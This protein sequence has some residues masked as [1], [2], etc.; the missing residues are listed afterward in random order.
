M[1]PRIALLALL[2]LSAPTQANRAPE[3][4]VDLPPQG[5]AVID[6]VGPVPA[7]AR[8]AGDSPWVAFMAP[9]GQTVRVRFARGLE[10]DPVVAQGYVDFLGSLVHGT[11]LARLRMVISPLRAVARRCGGIEGTLACYDPS[12]SQMTV[13][14][15]AVAEEGDGV[16][17]SYVIAHEYGHH[18]ARWRDNR[19]FNALA[20]GPKLWAS[21][22]LVCL[23]ALEDRLAPGD[24]G[25]RYL[26]N[27][28]EAWAS[29]YA[30]LRYP[31]THWQY[32][33]LLRPD[34]AAYAAALRDV[35]TP[36]TRS[37]RRELTGAFGPAGPDRRA[38]PVTL[39]LDGSL[40]IALDGP[41][42]A[43]YDVVIRSLGRRQGATRAAGADDVFRMRY[44][45]REVSAERLSVA[46]VRRSGRGPFSLTVT[47]AG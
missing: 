31:D 21:H 18:V 15:E 4:L 13:P 34:R 27:P 1:V 37:Q 22:E 44:A 23:H 14:G 47:Y 26:A 35:G 29:T 25:E 7:S 11:E 30:G 46:V 41:A 24:Q 45:C 16:T 28:G 8:A 36:W 42:G 9:D 20:M 2:A 17:T 12:T 33:D 38:F 6:R 43:E 5:G 39:R 10:P 40:T 19:P 32:V 3:P